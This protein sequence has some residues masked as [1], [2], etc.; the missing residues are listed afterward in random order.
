M[1]LGA[2][3]IHEIWADFEKKVL[4]PNAPRVQRIEMRKAFITGYAIALVNVKAVASAKD[5]DEAVA[6]M[7]Q[8]MMNESDRAVNSFTI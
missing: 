4:P 3:S 2:L 7:L 8:S 5:S 6:D 1:D